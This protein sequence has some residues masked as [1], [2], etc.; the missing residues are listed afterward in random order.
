MAYNFAFAAIIAFCCT[1]IDAFSLSACEIC[2]AIGII[3]AWL[4]SST[5]GEWVSGVTFFT[6]T[7]GPMIRW[8]T[9]GICYTSFIVTWI[10]TSAIFTCQMICTLWICWTSC[11]FT[12][13]YRRNQQNSMALVNYMKC[14]P[15]DLKER[16][17][18]T[19]YFWKLFWSIHFFLLILI[20]VNA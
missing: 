12:A 7:N 15:I 19:L 6:A 1:W 11:T 3:C 9:I 18:W 2:I 16:S 17:T 4:F 10:F 13:S 5:F 14:I 8:S 20:D